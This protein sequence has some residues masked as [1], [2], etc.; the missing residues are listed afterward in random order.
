MGENNN[1][2]VINEYQN[3]IIDLN[4][5]IDQ[6]L[7]NNKYLEINNELCNIIIH[8]MNSIY[9]YDINKILELKEKS[10]YIIIFDSMINALNPNNLYVNYKYN[11]CSIVFEFIIKINLKVSPFFELNKIVFVITI[12]VRFLFYCFPIL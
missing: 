8:N 6:N 5:I 2:L 7:V 4:Q 12:L 10:D 3:N 1:H 9:D 11:T